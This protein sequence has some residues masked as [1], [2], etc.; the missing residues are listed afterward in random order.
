ML[1][2]SKAQQVYDKIYSLI[3]T[4]SIPY[5]DALPTEE[6]LAEQFKVSRVTIRRALDILKEDG[7]IKGK[8]GQGNFVVKDL[9]DESLVG[10]EKMTHPLYRSIVCSID[11]VVIDLTTTFSNSHDC[12]VLK[13]TSA[14]IIKTTRWY[15]SEEQFVAFCQSIIDPHFIEAS[16]VSTEPTVLLDF[17]E[18]EIYQ[19]ALQAHYELLFVHVPDSVLSRKIQNDQ[20]ESYLLL[21]EIL[22]SSIG[23]TVCE[24][25]FYIPLT[26]AR[27]QFNSR[28]QNF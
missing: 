2:G 11:Q 24:N 1:D 26:Q 13:T 12:S 14:T 25:K 23:T 9:T 20:S 7:F 15:Q 17:L 5:G 6:K 16:N 8:R 18:K 27:I 10:L 3:A 4:G 28:N 21:R 19:K 22:Y